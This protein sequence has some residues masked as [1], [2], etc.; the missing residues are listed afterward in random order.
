MTISRA[1]LAG[2]YVIGLVGN[3]AANSGAQENDGEEGKANDGR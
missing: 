3:Q 1:I 2:R